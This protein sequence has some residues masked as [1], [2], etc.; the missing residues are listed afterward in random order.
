MPLEVAPLAIP[1]VKLIRPVR[2]G[3]HRGYFSET[4]SRR[5]LAEAGIATEFVQDN[6]A[7]SAEAGTVRGLHFQ[8]PP[9]AQAKLVRV[10]RGAIFD[11]AVDLRRGSPTYGQHV[12]AV[13]TAENWTQILVP[14]GFAH[15]L[16]TIAPDTEVFY[17]VSAFYAPEHDLGL[18]W[19]DPALAIAWP[20]EAAAAI[21]SAKDKVQPRLA[22]LPEHFRYDPPAT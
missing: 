7:L 21:L 18:L 11:V 16:A 22:D 3:D 8:V 6:Q 9:H 17:K 1:D 19:N 10:L 4:Y 5:A 14:V 20:V 2:H 13:L 12:S 15:G